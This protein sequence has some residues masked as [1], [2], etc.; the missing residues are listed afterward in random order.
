MFRF[1][2]WRL[3]RLNANRKEKKNKMKE[4]ELFIKE[5]QKSEE[6]VLRLLSVTNEF[7]KENPDTPII[8]MAM[9][10]MGMIS[11][12]CGETFGS[13]VT[14]ASHKEAS[15]PGQMPYKDVIEILDVFHKSVS[16]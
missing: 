2:H 15:A 14:F 8:T 12:L 9:G 1:K 3:D 6:D 10:K 16:I 5:E 11:R 7:Y 4:L 13:C